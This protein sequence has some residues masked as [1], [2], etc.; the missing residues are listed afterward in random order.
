MNTIRNKIIESKWNYFIALFTET[1]A[2]SIL[3][4]IGSWLWLYKESS[5]DLTY[6]RII[7]SIFFVLTIMWYGRY[8]KYV[9]EGNKNPMMALRQVLLQN[10]RTAV[11]HTKKIQDIINN[12][13][14]I[15]EIKSIELIELLEQT[16]KFEESINSILDQIFLTISKGNL[17]LDI[18]TRVS[19]LEPINDELKIKYYANSEKEMPRCMSMDVG[20]KKREGTAGWAWDLK[21]TYIIPDLDEYRKGV[22]AGTADSSLFLDSHTEQVKIKSICC[23]PVFIRTSNEEK[24]IGVIS[25]DSDKPYL[26]RETSQDESDIRIITYPFVR[27]IGLLYQLKFFIH[28]LKEKTVN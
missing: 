10:R 28:A 24:L 19:F 16:L 22:D 23:I 5:E 26:F 21:R 25:I 12:F 3:I 6:Q 27:Y 20:F 14:N 4:S 7:W 13:D 11:I 18:H 8:K 9:N 2:P 17:D 1:L 15:D